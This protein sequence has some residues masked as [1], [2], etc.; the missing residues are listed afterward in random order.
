MV[1][2]HDNDEW[3]HI[4]TWAE[5]LEHTDRN[6]RFTRDKDRDSSLS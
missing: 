1:E 6:E 2:A 3:A 4:T 5:P